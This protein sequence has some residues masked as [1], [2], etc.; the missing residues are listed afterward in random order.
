[1]RN[2]Q[3]KENNEEIISEKETDSREKKT[4]KNFESHEAF[5]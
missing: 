4:R 3:T 1:M 5:C 2:K